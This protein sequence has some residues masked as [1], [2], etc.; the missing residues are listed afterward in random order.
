M[1]E[2]VIVENPM[3]VGAGDFACTRHAAIRAAV[4]YESLIELHSLLS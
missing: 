4:V 3:Q 1:P 2:A